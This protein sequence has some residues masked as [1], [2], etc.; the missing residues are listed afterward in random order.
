LDERNRLLWRR[1]DLIKKTET[2]LS[3]PAVALAQ[4]KLNISSSGAALFEYAI[5]MT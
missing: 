1:L 5:G 3:I 2:M 4:A